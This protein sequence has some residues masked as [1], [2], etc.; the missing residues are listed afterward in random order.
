MKI[1]M[2]FLLIAILFISI[3]S[4]KE[5]LLINDPGNLVPKTADLDPDIPSVEING[6][7]LHRESFGH[8][9]STIVLVLHGGPGSDYRYLLRCKALTEY[10]YKV[11]FYDQRGTGLS[12][13]FPYSI[14]N[15]QIMYDDLSGIIDH[16]KSH[17]NQK[18]IL[19]GHSWGAMLATAYINEYP[20]AIAGVILCEPGGLKWK[21]V[22]DY[23]YRSREIGFFSE[24][25]NDAVYME[26]FITGKGDEH[27][28]LDYKFGLWAAAEEE[29]PIGNEG[30]L[31][32]W[33]GGAVT[34]NALFDTAEKNS[35]DWTTHLDKFDKEILFVYSESNKAYGSIHAQKVSSAYQKVTLFETKS[36]GHDM[37]TFE[38]GW[39]NTLPAIIS[40]LN[41]IN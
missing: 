5:E 16:Y 28:I 9:D 10:G 18:I 14:Y 41:K 40:Y 25:L 26:Q 17:E 33:R 34:F 32:S 13:R 29:S 31:P 11:V 35:P 37:L 7:I 6:A 1:I 39:N 38:K 8:P 21:D 15:M 36:A 19:L 23:L 12:Q 2:Y 22:E 24:S 4:C 27:A 20:E 30:P 3:S